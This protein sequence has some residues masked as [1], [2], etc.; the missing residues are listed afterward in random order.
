MKKNS[1]IRGMSIVSVMVGVGIAGAAAY[2]LSDLMISSAKMNRSSRMSSSINE[3]RNQFSMVGK[4]PA[5]W[6]TKL[7]QSPT[8]KDIFAPCLVNTPN[9]TFKC[10]AVDEK[11]LEKD[12]ELKKIA[13]AFHPASTPLIDI[14]GQKI[15]GTSKEPH[16]M[17][18]ETRPC[19]STPN[20]CPL[21]STGYFF[22]ESTIET[23]APGIV[24]F[25]I[26]IEKNPNFNL[27]NEM[28][29][30]PSYISFFVG[31]AWMN[32]SSTS[33]TGSS[34][35]SSS[36]EQ[37]RCLPNG[38]ATFLPRLCCSKLVV[39]LN[40]QFTV[41][42][43]HGAVQIFTLEQLDQGGGYQQNNGQVGRIVKLTPS[44][45]KGSRIVYSNDAMYSCSSQ[46]MLHQ[47]NALGFPIYL[48]P[49]TC[50]A[51]VNSEGFPD[52]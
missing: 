36:S 15:A 1:S 30:K 41:G 12:P 8:T 21:Q 24:S 4:D 49:L 27:I 16:Y 23:D 39:C 3:I 42:I 5:F 51:G 46:G 29:M 25:V 37:S 31:K 44:V 28:P 26:I 14:N 19:D 38:T 18:A 35:S 17:D 11:L 9:P 47:S 43:N 10:P 48:S 2:I 22:R 6:L 52:F 32:D 33:L 34:S 7:R 45:I 13:G 20:L 50:V 40:P